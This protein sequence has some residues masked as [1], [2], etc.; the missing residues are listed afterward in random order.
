MVLGPDP[1][2]KATTHHAAAP[3]LIP[4]RHFHL[5]TMDHNDDYLAA[6]AGTSTSTTFVYNRASTL[7][8][9]A[10]PSFEGLEDGGRKRVKEDFVDDDRG[11]NEGA[12][13]GADKDSSVLADELAQELQCGCCSALVYRPVIVS[14][15]Q[16]FFCGR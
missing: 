8:R 15:C 7:K 4:P 5:L 3:A 11:C 1:R 6:T 9:R 2:R 13:T 14:P 12:S 10:S 16:H